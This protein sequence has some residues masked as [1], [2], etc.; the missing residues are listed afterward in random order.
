MITVNSTKEYI[1]P[2]D[3]GETKTA[4]VLKPMTKAKMIEL[5]KTALKEGGES[6][7]SRFLS[8]AGEAIDIIK[9]CVV[10]VKNIEIN[11]VMKDVDGITDEILELLP[12]DVFMGIF[13]EIMGSARAKDEEKKN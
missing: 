8:M 3:T 7:Q 9:E 4:F 10:K 1:S 12:M 5:S 2:L 6:D 11:G 13:G